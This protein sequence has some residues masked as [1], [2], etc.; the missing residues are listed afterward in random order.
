MSD[1]HWRISRAVPLRAVILG[2][3]II[4]PLTPGALSSQTSTPS[5]L[6]KVDVFSGPVEC[7]GGN[8]CEIRVACPEVAAPARA[9]LKVGVSSG[10]DGTGV[11]SRVPQV[12][13]RR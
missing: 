2:V 3:V 5:Q 6:G 11:R 10:K 12:S 1:L 13:G 7:D 9:R 4:C 8:C